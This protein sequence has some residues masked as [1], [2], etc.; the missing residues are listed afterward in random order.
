MR[1]GWDSRRCE[2]KSK[3]RKY[4][5][6]LYDISLFVEDFSKILSKSGI[7]HF[8]FVFNTVKDEFII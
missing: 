8:R 7:I 5:K 4:K 2:Y 6:L 3:R 1:K